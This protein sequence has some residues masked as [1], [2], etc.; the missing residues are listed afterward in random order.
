MKFKK[1][2]IQ[3]FRAYNKVE[4]GIFDFTTKP[5]EIADFISI[6]A[7]NGFGKT[8][9]YDAVEW[10][11]TN[12]INRFLM[13]IDDNKDSI[14]AENSKHILRNK[15]ADRGTETVVNLYTTLQEK[16]FSRTIGQLKGRQR[17]FRFEPKD[18]IP[19]RRYF[20][21]VLLS[22]EWIDAF[23]KE[24]D[25][26][27]RYDKFVK[28][29]GF[30]NLN[31]RYKVIIELLKHNESEINHL[32][33]ELQELQSK[34]NFDFDHE[35]LLKINSAI[36]LLNKDGENVPIVK[37]DWTEKN[38]QQL[39]DLISERVADLCYKIGKSRERI[40]YID[41]TVTGSNLSGISLELYFANKKQIKRLNDKLSELNKI[42]KQFEQIHELEGIK[43]N[44][45]DVFNKTI[46]EQSIFIDLLS[47][48]PRYQKI[49]KEIISTNEFISKTDEEF[50]KIN[51]E[52]ST[53][54]KYY[55]ELDI[56]LISETENFRKLSSRLA[57][58]P[59][60]SKSLD[61]K[62]SEKEKALGKIKSS[63]EIKSKHEEQIT[64]TER[65]IRDWEAFDNQISVNDY[66]IL[67]NDKT[68]T[69]NEAIKRLKLRGNQIN[70]I[71][72]IV[73]DTEIEMKSANNLNAEIEQLIAKGADIVSKSQSSVCPLCK[74]EY[75]NFEIL[76]HKISD[77]SFL[78]ER[79]KNLLNLKN[80]NEHNLE[81]LLNL[82]KK[83]KSNIQ[84][85]IKATIDNLKEILSENIKENNK[86]SDVIDL[87]KLLN[88]ELDKEI[89]ELLKE[90]GGDD[91]EVIK[92]D[93]DKKIKISSKIIEELNTN[94]EKNIKARLPFE[95]RKNIISKHEKPALEE[96]IDE[97]K[98]D[99]SYIRIKNFMN[100]NQ[101]T[102]DN[103]DFEF[104]KRKG[105]FQTKI[106]SEKAD[107]E[108]CD[109]SMCN[110]Q[111]LVEKYEEKS[112]ISEVQQV[113]GE[114]EVLYKTLVAFEYF[115]KS[116]FEIDLLDKEKSELEIYLKEQ[117]NFCKKTIFQMEERI[118]S[119]EKIKKYKESV[120]PFLKHDEFKRTEN[121]I[122]TNKSFLE[123]KVHP[124][125]ELEKQQISDYI[126]K[127]IES[128]FH[129]KLINLLYQKIDPHPIYKEIKFNCDFSTDK[130]RLNVFVVGGRDANTPIVPTLYF[131]TAQLNILSLSIFLAK[132]LN[133]KDNN[134]KAV[135][136]IFI[137]DP[138]QSMDSINILS[139]IDLLRSISVNLG[140]QIVLA[141]HD[142]N[143]HNL[144]Q[145][146]IPSNK[147]NAKYIE[148]ETFGKVKS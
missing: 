113:S 77:N 99:S 37:Y 8:S 84:S 73:S 36:E 10:G 119:F 50:E 130:P 147:F 88:K 32:K 148:L 20:Q 3:A 109:K 111:K 107:I 6:Y 19:E 71:K 97:L 116:K 54:S 30:E 16:P 95:Q 128:F 117:D 127:Q 143:F 7:P 79:M 57:V 145:K 142:E 74:Q 131:S 139:T 136:C 112:V 133:V 52:L 60:L 120:L 49:S 126:D 129:G 82:Q 85:Q 26:R 118:Q 134:G 51:S 144:L 62:K 140:K 12:N 125:L 66:Q 48:Y 90:I 14:R 39:T 78:S 1:V 146:K 68:K 135:D 34:I 81:N 38:I 15:N 64:I 42:K 100:E 28:S 69:F 103:I 89:N 31:Q 114:K 132:A 43:K 137:D 11:F 96:K 27:I 72:K 91:I 110:Y 102:D 23:L 104:D 94:K 106:T 55:S 63:S 5:D 141:T 56:K 58:I 33:K 98:K 124:K 65:I 29:F 87:C 138:I 40:S 108:E 61:T 122:M 83:E 21:E 18:T 44:R 75:D 47:A 25:A 24:D 53:Y 101:F 35:I 105:C 17:D 121:I 76:V 86:L 13:R 9:F 46:K 41:S 115:I 4:D 92:T 80:K 70:D 123:K 45:E 59:E 93:I 67:E 2:E 22:Q